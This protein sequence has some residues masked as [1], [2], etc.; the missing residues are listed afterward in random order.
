M[1]ATKVVEPNVCRSSYQMVHI[2]LKRCKKLSHFEGNG[3]AKAD[4]D[5]ETREI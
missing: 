4:T 1:C 3:P 5:F 2:A